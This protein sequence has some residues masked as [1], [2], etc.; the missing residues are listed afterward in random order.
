MISQ[1]TFIVS[2]I[3]QLFHEWFGLTIRVKSW[4]VECLYLS[5]LWIQPILRY[6][7]MGFYASP[8]KVETIV[9]MSKFSTLLKI[10]MELPL[11]ISFYYWEKHF[12]FLPCHLFSQLV[13]FCAR[14]LMLLIQMCC[15]IHTVGGRWYGSI[16]GAK[17]GEALLW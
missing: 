15:K 11:W 6:S 1:Y 3:L 8:L 7:K 13:S 9:N 2:C 4:L 10:L 17:A 14:I 12:A 5:L 16:M